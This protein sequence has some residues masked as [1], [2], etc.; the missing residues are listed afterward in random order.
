MYSQ[1]KIIR[2]IDEEFENIMTVKR[3]RQSTYLVLCNQTGN[4]MISRIIF[5]LYDK[6]EFQWPP[7]K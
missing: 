6:Q 3:Y 4:S 1:K 2:T 5:A 7:I